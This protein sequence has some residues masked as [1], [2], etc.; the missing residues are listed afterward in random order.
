ME[1][2]SAWVSA[3]A[4][5]SVAPH[6]TIKLRLTSFCLDEHR[7]GPA[8]RYHVAAKRLPPRLLAALTPTEMHNQVAVWRIRETMMI[9]LEGDVAAPPH[10]AKK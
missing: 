5:L 3:P 6:Q 7:D 10:P 1:T 9:S 2:P 8:G 4:T